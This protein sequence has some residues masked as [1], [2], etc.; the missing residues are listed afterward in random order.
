MGLAPGTILPGAYTVLKPANVG[1]THEVLRL[2]ATGRP[3]AV[4][5]VSTL[6]MLLSPAWP[7][8][9]V[10]DEQAAPPC[11]GLANGYEQSKWVADRLVARARERGIPAAIYRV[12]LLTGE[13]RSGRFTKEADFFPS[14]LKGCIQLG[15]MPE[16]ATQTEL[17]PVDYA[18]RA[19]VQIARSHPAE[20]RGKRLCCSVRLARNQA[21]GA[22]A[23]AP[24]RPS[25]RSS[26]AF[27][28]A[29]GKR[30]K[31]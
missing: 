10:L 29:N 13:T 9:T 25:S 6:G 12:G 14:W 20:S 19:I 30:R 5:F 21:W 22:S 3:K 17:V 24:D 1:G 18:S 31:G 27:H 15:A 4:H 23:L 16:L 11:E 2:A 26:S 8:D 28:A 7:R